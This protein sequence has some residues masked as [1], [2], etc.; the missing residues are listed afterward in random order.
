MIPSSAN[1][2]VPPRAQ[3]YRGIRMLEVLRTVEV[4]PRMRRVTFGGAEL[5][6]FGEGPNLKLLIPPPHLAVPELPVT[7]AD[8]RAIWPPDERK[9]TVRTYS[10]RAHRP[11]QGEID[12]DFVL[13]GNGGVAASWAAQAKRGDIV[14]IGG[15]GGRTVTQADWYLFA[16]DH[17]A[18]PAIAAM[19]EKLP[20]QARGRA[21]I[22]VSDAAEQQPLNTKADIEIVWLHRNGM[23]ADGGSL[24]PDA[25]LGTSW[26]D[27]G[28]VFAWAGCESSAVRTI[29]AHWRDERRLDRR[30]IL[31]IG[32]WRRGMTEQAY[33][34]AFNN[35]RDEDYYRAME[36]EKKTQVSPIEG[37]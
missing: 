10:L 26:P 24:L 2:A 7:G 33:K 34:D 30:H 14:G 35:D 12:V 21:F 19:L 1:P 4:T 23:P 18:L 13:H 32:Y 27:A 8:G 9:P 25:V 16:G 36:M 22:E 11:E 29:R 28:R 15:P 3:R 20:A 6:G 31:A 5:E 37:D 17:S